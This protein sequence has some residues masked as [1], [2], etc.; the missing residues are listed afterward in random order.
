MNNDAILMSGFSV[1]YKAGSALGGAVVG[2]LMPVAYVA[3]AETQI[4][5]VQNFF[6]RWSTA[7]PCVAFA[8]GIIALFVIMHYERDIKEAAQ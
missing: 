3:G 6:F 5:S 4:E 7:Y 2:F 8:I 1:S